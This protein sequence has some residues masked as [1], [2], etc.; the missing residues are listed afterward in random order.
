MTRQI[1]T[2]GILR[3]VDE[4][5]LLLNDL[6]KKEGFSFV[7]LTVPDLYRDFSK[8]FNHV[9]L[10]RLNVQVKIGDELVDSE[11]FKMLTS[12][13]YLLINHED[14]YVI[15]LKCNSILQYDDRDSS[16]QLSFKNYNKTKDFLENLVLKLRLIKSGNIGIV[17]YFSIEMPSKTVIMKGIDSSWK[18]QYQISLHIDSNDISTIQSMLPKRTPTFEYFDLALKSF[19]LSYSISNLSLR[20][21]SLITSLECLFN[22]G[23][24]QIAHTI[25]RHTALFISTTRE[26]FKSNYYKIKKLYSRRN[27][28]VHGNITKDKIKFSDV[29]LLEE[30]VRTSL[31]EISLLNKDKKDLF[32]FLNIK[33]FNVNGNPKL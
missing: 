20:F 16:P 9:Y 2:Y 4:S 32:D 28:I 26:E 5:I 31:R 12:N 1:I 22:L 14:F 19:E 7:K 18:Q 15:F 3:N 27:D 25:S 30:F 17:G 11:F 13:Q 10:P 23:K 24:D 6:I 21:I 8:L 29:S 33:G